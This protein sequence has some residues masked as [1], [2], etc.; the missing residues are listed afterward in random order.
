MTGHPGI[1]AGMYYDGYHLQ[2]RFRSHY[3]EIFGEWLLNDRV[4]KP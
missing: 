2:F 4:G 3:T 1:D